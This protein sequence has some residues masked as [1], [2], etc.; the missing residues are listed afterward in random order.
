[1]FAGVGTEVP[2]L[3]RNNLSHQLSWSPRFAIALVFLLFF[4]PASAQT[5]T[6]QADMDSATRDSLESTA[7]T[8]AQRIAAQGQLAGAST[9]QSSIAPQ[10]AAESAGI[11]NSISSAAPLVKG[12]SFIVQN[13]YVLDATDSPAN[14]PSTQF[15]CGSMNQPPH[16]I[17]TLGQLPQARYAVAMVHAMSVPHP[18]Q[19]TM[20]FAQAPSV[21]PQ[22]AQSKTAPQ[23]D[24]WKLAGFAYKPLTMAGHDGVWYWKRARAY[25]QQ[26]QNWNAYFYYQT[27][28]NLVSPVDFLSSSNLNKLVR[29]QNAVMPMGLPGAQPMVLAN[30]TQSFAVTDL[31][32]DSFQGGLDLVIHYQ[33]KSL[34]DL[35]ATR[36]HN[37]AVMHL[38]LQA[39]PEL[40]QAFH[41]LWVYAVAPGQ[42]PFGIELPMNQI[43]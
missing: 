19:M 23:Q 2:G 16:V 37:I 9:L 31:H 10:V 27:A 13:L 18:Q 20:I 43:P 7:I 38:M 26:K 42:D 35:V 17:F 33:A 15:F 41:G 30:G 8:M 3:W 29:E 36:Q 39:H 12:A 21:P 11:L 14:V 32:T 24:A 4:H 25:A 1:M 22:S 40:R 5:C 34:Q 28:R 6:T